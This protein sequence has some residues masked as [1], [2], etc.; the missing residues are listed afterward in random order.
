MAAVQMRCEIDGCTASWSVSSPAKMK[1]SM[2]EHRRKFHPGWVQ[3]PPKPMS[4]YRLDYG[5]RARQF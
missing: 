1:A 5:G 3:P 4:P 2:E